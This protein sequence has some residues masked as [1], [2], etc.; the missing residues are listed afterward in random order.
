M[1]SN[2]LFKLDDSVHQLTRKLVRRQS[3]WRNCVKTF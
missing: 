3:V 2:L 1:G